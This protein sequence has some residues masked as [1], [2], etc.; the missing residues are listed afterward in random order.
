MININDKIPGWKSELELKR[1]IQLLSFLNQ[2]SIIVEIGA[3]AGR[4]TWVL[5]KNCPKNSKI[6]AI[7]TWQPEIMFVGNGYHL[8]KNQLNTQD[9]FNKFMKECLNDNVIAIKGDSL[10]IN[11]FNELIDFCFID[12]DLGYK[13]TNLIEH[14]IKW[15]PQIKGIMAGA[16]YYEH[17]DDVRLSVNNFAALNN[18]IL[19]LFTDAGI[20]W[21]NFNEK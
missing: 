13:R 11:L 1:I 19:H 18:K 8:D 2:N 17:R 6:Y 4:L 14:L 10:K 12:P 5:S 20:W 7:D 16:N 15:K 3:S 9:Y 21:I